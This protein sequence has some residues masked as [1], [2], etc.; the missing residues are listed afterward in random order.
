MEGG[1][2]PEKKLKINGKK[3]KKWKE[4]RRKLHEKRGKGLKNASF[5]VINSKQFLGGPQLY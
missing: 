1:W 5:G 3:L 2:P 4:R